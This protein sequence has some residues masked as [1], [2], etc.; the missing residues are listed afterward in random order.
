MVDTDIDTKMQD[1]IDISP[2]KFCS[3]AT[4]AT[5]YLEDADIELTQG[6]STDFNYTCFSGFNVTE[7]QVAQEVDDTCTE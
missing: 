6:V 3:H 5:G 7:N 1:I 2:F 4:E